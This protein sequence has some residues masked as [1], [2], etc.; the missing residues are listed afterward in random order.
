M[1]NTEINKQLAKAQKMADKNQSRDLTLIICND[2]DIYRQSI[3][4][5]I[6]NLQKKIKKGIFEPTQAI[7]AFYNIVL[8]ALKNPRFSRY[9]TYNIKMVDVPTRYDTAVQ[10]AEHFEDEIF[11]IEEA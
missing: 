5:T 3:Q 6:A 7:Q 1:T 2:G 11:E 4:P 8:S 10:V 9:Y